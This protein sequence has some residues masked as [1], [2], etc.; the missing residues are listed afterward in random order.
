MTIQLLI[1]GIEDGKAIH[2]QVAADLKALNDLIAVAS[3]RVTLQQQRDASPPCQAMATLRISGPDIHAAARD[4]AWPAAWRK[5]AA[6]L[7]EQM[8][9][10]RP[11]SLR[12][13]ER[14]K[15]Q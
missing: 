3:A 15:P 6:R 7:R 11:A 10:R 13:R 9:Q 14:V 4:H 2:R 1:E 5:V 8:E 12:V